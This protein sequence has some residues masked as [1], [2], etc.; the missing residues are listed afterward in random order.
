MRST[1]YS[2]SPVW[3]GLRREGCVPLLCYVI[4]PILAEQKCNKAASELRQIYMRTILSKTI[5][6]H[7]I[8]RIYTWN[9]LLE[10][11]R[12]LWP[13]LNLHM[14]VRLFV[15]IPKLLG[16]LQL[17]PEW[18]F[19]DFTSLFNVFWDAF[20]WIHSRWFQHVPPGR[21]P[22]MDPP[23]TRRS[24]YPLGYRS[25]NRLPEPVCPTGLCW[26]TI[27]LWVGRIRRCWTCFCIFLVHFIVLCLRMQRAVRKCRAHPTIISHRSRLSRTSLRIEQQRSDASASY[28]IC[29][30]D[31]ALFIYRN[32]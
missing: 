29:Q 12:Y 17:F 30:C 11:L 10:K 5:E 32:L 22:T 16:H 4:V 7:L 18:Q 15:H 24:L 9:I 23:Q 25:G 31:R 3:S 28:H 21:I 8:F 6:N 20:T 2:I 27:Y 26:C 19:P 14:L 13:C 1:H